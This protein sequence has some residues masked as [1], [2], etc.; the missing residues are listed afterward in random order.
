MTS[1][2]T[3]IIRGAAIVSLFTL[4]GKAAAC[5]LRPIMAYCFGTGLEADAYV[6][7]FQSIGFAFTVVPQKTLAPFL[8]LFVEKREREGEQKAW[9]FVWTIAVLL[10][11]ILGI[12]V[13][14][15]IYGAPMLVKGV[16]NFKTG[17][18]TRLAVDLTRWILPSSFFLGLSALAY[19]VLNSY[20][21]FALP[22]LGDV[23]NKCVVILVVLA[24][25][26]AMGIRAMA[27]GV[28]L[29]ALA[30]LLLQVG[31]LWAG[32]R[33]F[34]VRVDFKDPAIRQMVRLSLPVLA[35][36]LFAQARTILDFRFASA[37]GEGFVSSLSYAKLL[38]D[39]LMLV[40]PYAVGV[41][42]YPFFAELAAKQDR[43][44]L[45]EMVMSSMRMLA[46]VFIP[47]TVALVA[48]RQPIVQVVFER[49]RFGP[50][51][52]AMTTGP[53]AWYALGL[54]TFAVEI[55]LMQFYFAMKDTVTP[56]VVGV[57]ALAVHVGVILSLQG[58]MLHKSI[59]F[60]A[61]VSKTLK[62]L[63]LYVFLRWKV[64][65][66]RFRENSLFLGKVLLA[67]AVM[68][69]VLAVAH[70]ILARMPAAG[71]SGHLLRL[72]LLLG[73]LGVAGLAGA[74]CYMALAL[75]L[76][77]DEARQL[78]DWVKKRGRHAAHQGGGDC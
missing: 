59:A 73:R 8:P 29:G 21:R 42:I 64:G 23:L 26:R 20:K 76:R 22:P 60:A 3:R 43:Q 49:G 61:V 36:A 78:L 57:L 17:E 32:I 66:L 28:V 52:V 13:A 70:P 45:T 16:A 72:V 6:L 69:G 4:A 30:C 53:L 46:F 18:V 14:A 24:V 65:D 38:P 75:L 11:A 31:G 77:I 50:E 58:F 2:S 1:L 63:V 7:A 54:T 34:S 71:D 27:L 51:S 68:G 44:G 37:M 35:G 5:F 47:M 67:A 25:Y 19:L 48:L 9:T 39:T 55:I 33:S 12:V 15:G 74:A 41:S 56:I 62:I 40:V 10:T